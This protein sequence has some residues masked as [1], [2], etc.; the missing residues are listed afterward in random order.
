ME[1]PIRIALGSL[2]L[3]LS[4]NALGGGYYGMAGARDVPA[5]WLEGSPFNNYFIPGLFLFV[6]IGGS[7]LLAAILVFRRHRHARQTALACGTITLLWIAIQVAIIGY[8]SW[9]QPATTVAALAILLL[10]WRMHA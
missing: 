10:A 1:K 2:L 6:V 9:M 3:L 4:V 5:E 7:A 8:V